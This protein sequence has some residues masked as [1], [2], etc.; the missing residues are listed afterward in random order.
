[1]SMLTPA[2]IIARDYARDEATLHAALV[3]GSPT[4][5]SFFERYGA[6]VNE[7]TAEKVCRAHSTDLSQ[8]MRDE[9][10]ILRP[11]RG[12][13]GAAHLFSALGY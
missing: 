1:M 6:Y 5:E 4:Y 2:G 3:E 7:A 10:S 9:P 8:L 13:Y 12:S 11:Q